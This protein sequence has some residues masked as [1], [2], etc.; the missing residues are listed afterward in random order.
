MDVVLPPRPSGRQH[1][2]HKLALME[3]LG[4]I[5]GA[6]PPKEFITAPTDLSYLKYDIIFFS[7]KK[8]LSS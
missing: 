3:P 7:N 8:S 4:S 2:H 6:P 1:C 5:G